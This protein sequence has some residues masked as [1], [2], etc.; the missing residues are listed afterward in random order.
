MFQNDYTEFESFKI[1]N[2]EDVG[3]QSTNGQSMTF[4]NLNEATV[5]ALL[6]QILL[7][8][9]FKIIKFEKMRTYKDQSENE[10]Q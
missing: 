2:L 10:H 4:R 1:F 8:F 3:A 7:S 6:L 9:K 5:D